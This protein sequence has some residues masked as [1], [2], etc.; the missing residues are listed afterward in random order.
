[1]TPV[2]AA[3][4]SLI[5]S[6]IAQKKLVQFQLDGHTRI[7][8]PHDYGI[9]KGIAQVLVYQIAGASRSG[10]LPDWRWIDLSRATDFQ[11]LDQNFRGRRAAPS[12][13][14]AQWDRV[15]VRV[16]DNTGDAA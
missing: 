10:R 9:R 12:G 4:D 13:K 1:M 15:F 14:H 6:A 7:S 3:T 11:I 2:N 5:R 8:E 16:D